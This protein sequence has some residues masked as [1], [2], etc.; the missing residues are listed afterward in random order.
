MDAVSVRLQ[1]L[2]RFLM[3]GFLTSLDRLKPVYDTVYK[4]VLFIC[5]IFLIGDIR[6]RPGPKRWF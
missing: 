2:W 4:A 6:T 3:K 5:K 1:N